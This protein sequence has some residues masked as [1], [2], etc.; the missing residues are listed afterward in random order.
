[1]SGS[2]GQ[3]SPFPHMT[4]QNYRVTSPK[5]NRYNCIAWAVGETTVFW[6]PDPVAIVNREAVWPSGVPIECSF[7]AFKMAFA[8]QRFEPCLDGDLEVGIEKIAIYGKVGKTGAIEP[9]H[10]ALQLPD[11][12]WTSKL[13]R[14]VDICHTLPSVLEGPQYGMAMHFMKRAR[15]SQVVN[16]PS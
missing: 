6:W 10:A 9:S 14:N 7:E 11:G 12:T 2:L 13:G 3:S 4:G 15:T 1:M 5:S 16:T 8:T